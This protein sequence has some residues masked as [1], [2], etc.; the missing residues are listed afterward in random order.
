MA[1]SGQTASLMDHSLTG[2]RS[3]SVGLVMQFQIGDFVHNKTS[4]EEG[5]IVRTA[6]LPGYGFRYIVSVAP[7]PVWGMT[8]TEAIWK[9]SYVSKGSPLSKFLADFF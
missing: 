8:A 1:P 9:R 6:D 2:G 7:S 4:G 3:C 5:R